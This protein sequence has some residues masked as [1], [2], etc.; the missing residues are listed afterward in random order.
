MLAPERA[1]AREVNEIMALS[2]VPLPFYGQLPYGYQPSGQVSSGSAGSANSSSS[3][4]A[5]AS[6]GNPTDIVDIRSS[7]SGFTAAAGDLFS[8]GDL[9]AAT[10]P[11]GSSIAGYKVAIRSDQAPPD[12]GQLLLG[13]K[14]VT[15]QLSFTADEF[16]RLHFKTGPSGSQQDLVVV[17]Q[18]G[19]RLADG[20][21]SN[22]VDSPATQ[23]T[24]NV[25][26]TRSINAVGA[27]LTRAAGT[28]ADFINT[29]QEA[30]IFTG[31]GKARPGLSTVGNFTA[32]A[33][34]LF[35]VNDL[36]A[37]TAPTGSSIAN[38]KI[39]LRSDQ[40]PPGG[41]QLLLGDKDVT[42][43]LSFTADEFSRLHFKVGQSGSTQDLVVVAQLGTRQADGT[44]SNV[45]DSPATQITANVTGTRS[46]NGIGALLTRATGNDADFVNTAQ[47]ASIFTG[48]GKARP[49]LTTVGNLSAAAGDLF[50]VGNLYAATAPAGSSIANYKVALRSDQAPPNGGQL[51]LGD[52]DVT[53][54]LSF[55][56]DEFSRLHFKA[57][58]SGSQQDLVVVAQ[59]GTRSADG[60]LSNAVD[61]PATQITANVTGVRSINAV[62]ALL[63]RTAEADSNFVSIAQEAS[64]FTGFGQARPA[65]NT[66]GNFTAAAGDLL[67]LGDLYA[68]T[69]P[70]GSSIA[71]YKVAIRSDQAPPNNGQLLLG[72][73]DVTGQLSFT[74]DEFSRLHFKTGPSGSTQDLVV[75]AQLGTRQADGT[76]SNVIDSPAV[77]I[78]AS[79][80]GVR[81]INASG[82]LL[83]RA[84]G[85][86]ADFVHT[87]Q[88]AS[89]FTGFGRPRPGLSTVGNLSAATGDL[90]SLNDL[91]TATAP[92][93][94]SIASYKV[95]LRSSQGASNNGQLLLGDKDVTGQ[96]SFT[97]DEFSRLHFKAG[98]AGSQQDLVVVAQ[99]GT[100][101]AD[102]TLFNVVNSPAVQITASV[103]GTRSINAV[104]ALLTRAA[105]S[106]ADF[107]NTA[108][109]AAIFT[110]F[111]RARPGLSTVGMPND[112]QVA[113]TLL[114]SL[115]GRFQST[116]T[117]ASALN[118]PTA[119]NGAASAAALL[120]NPRYAGAIGASRTAGSATAGSAQG[121][122]PWLL[123]PSDP[124]SYQTGGAG[125]TLQKFAVAAY[126]ASQKA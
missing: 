72:D 98:P 16:S 74:A 122:A 56:A 2:S 53:G 104:G 60:T 5:S 90:F 62:G 50:S 22:A 118:A 87:A 54:Q 38:Y 48:F 24:A 123:N 112:P 42:G 84:A 68:A 102:G 110:G 44:L 125:L 61:S 91:Y 103:T 4:T 51:L 121:T 89:I 58:P 47:E 79:V 107:V 36:Y 97:A 65:L 57:G 12:G 106:D 76:L 105:G 20:T 25:T 120:L 23:I 29:A 18:L 9:C 19:T 64:I 10:A 35:S 100:R 63:N 81:S 27:L 49:S 14:D 31:F 94:S 108:Q 80:T 73:K 11:A 71:N 95:A 78:T 55:T 101:S 66:V 59:L 30:S 82:A 99:L 70:T 85:D 114:A 21:L 41:G 3:K 39:A 52:K 115:V 26:G 75:L 113:E 93:G 124:G 15:G 33:D 1:I 6:S 8:L 17:A 86:D 117:V 28:D 116:Q 37:A 83:T 13:D 67:S 92:T 119:A 32:A 126:Q 43:Q 45:I 111:G 7:R 96:L 46:L 109:E 77:Q 69:A 88:D 40:A 34:D